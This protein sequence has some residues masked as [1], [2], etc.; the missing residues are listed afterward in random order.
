MSVPSFAARSRWL[1]ALAALALVFTQLMGTALPARAAGSASLTAAGTAYTE[2]FD[3]LVSTG[4]GTLAANTPL[5]WNFAESGTNANTIYTAGTGSNNAG[6]T[7]SFGATSASDRAFGGLLSGSVTPTIGASFINNTGSTIGALD[8]AYTGEQWRIG[9]TTTA[10]DDRLDF[11]YS[12]DATSLTTGTWVDVNSLD[13]TNPIKTAATTAALD[14]NAS[15]NR[16]AIS[17]SIT[18]QNIP[19]G[20]TFWIRWSDFN[21]TGSDDSLAIDDFSLT[22]QGDAATAPSITTGPQSQ[23]ITSGQTAT[24]SVVASGTTPLSY[25]WYQGSAGDTSAPVGANAASYTTPALTA[26]TSYWV[27]V[28]NSAGSADSGTATITVSPATDQPIATGGATSLATTEGS[29]ASAVVTASDPDSTITGATITSAAVTGIALNG[30]AST[31]N[32]SGSDASVS[33]DVGASVPAGSYPVDIQFANNTGQTASA[34]VAVTVNVPAGSCPTPSTAL[35]GIPALQG[36]ADTNTANGQNR[37][38]RGVVSVDVQGSPG[39]NGFYLQDPAGDGNLQTSDGVFVFVPSANSPWFGFDVAVGDALQ[40]SG[41][42]TEFQGMTEI[43]TVTSIV[44]CGTNATIAPATVHLPEATNGELERYEG[45]LVSIP[46]TLTVQQNFF[47]GRYGQVTLGVGGRLYQPTNRY[48]AGSAQA[49][50]AADSNARSMIVLD[51]ANSAQNPSALPYI[52]AGNTLRAGDTTSGLVGALDFGA[53]NS[54][55]TIHDYRLQPTQPVVFTRVNDRTAAPATVG[56]NLKVA[57]FNVLNYFN[58]DGQGGGFPTSRGANTLVEFNRQRDKIIAAITA[59]DPAVAG[60]MEM[61]NDG[62]GALSAVQDLVNGL[63]AATSPGKYALVAEPAPGSDQI[64]VAMIYQPA[65]V[66]PSGTAVNYQVGDP[67]YGAELFDRPPLAQTFQHVA[68]GQIFTVIVNHFKSKGSCPTSGPDTDQGDGQGCW[69]PKRTRQAQELLGFIGARQ[70]A[71]GDLDVLVIGDL[72]SYGMEDPIQ[73]LTAGGLVNTIQ[74]RIGDDAYSYV[75]DGMSGYLDHALATSSLDSQISG[76][77]EWHINADEPSVIDYN[78]EFKNNP[79]CTSTTCTSPDY[80]AATPFRAS[81]HDPVLVGLSLS[82]AP[83]PTNPSGVGSASPASVTAGSA[84]LLTVTVTPGANPASSGLSVS[85]DLTA[86]GGLATQAF[87]DNGTNG[88]ATAGDNIFSFSATVAAATTAGAKSLPFTVAD[89]QA[90]SG[91]GTIALT[92][93]APAASADVVISQVYGGGGNTGATFKNDFIELYNRG[94]TPADLTGWSVQYASAAN[95]FS[96]KTNLAGT[97]QPGQYYLIQEAAGTGGTTNLPTPDATGTIAMSAT[98]GKVALVNNQ[99]LL[100]CGAAANNCFPNSAIVDFV[101][102]GTTA[103]N[104]EGSGPAPAPSN[105][106]AALRNGNGATDT[107]NNSADFTVGTPTPR[108]SSFGQ[109]AS[110]SGV[111][112]ASPAS[113]TAGSATLLTVTVTPG[114]NPASSGLSVSADLTAIGGSATQAFVDNGT[115]GDATAGDNIFSFSATVAAATTAGAKSL[116][117]TVADAQ[118]RSGSGSIALTVTAAVACSAPDVA[119][120]S[121]Q[122]SGAATSASGTVTVQGVVVGDYEGASPAL[123][124]FYLQDS[125]DGDT[126]TS[127][128][129][130]VFEGDNANR[131]GVG[132]VV[133]V[134]GTPGENQGQTQISSTT[135]VEVCGSTA[136]LTPTDVALPV[137][138]AASGVDY[139]ER[140]EGMLVRFAQTLYVTEHFQ[141]GRFGQVVLSS[142]ERL[143]Q[144]TNV[145]APGAP[146]LALQAQN[147]LS[148]IILDDASQA[149]NPDPIVFARGGSP[150]SAANTLRGGDSVANLSGVMTYTWAGN[151]ASGNAYRIRPIGALGGGVPNFQPANPRPAAAPNVGGS[152]RVAGMNLL[153]FFN[154][155]DGLP[156]TVDNCTNGVGGAPTDCR[157]ADTQAEFDRQW[158]KTITAILALNPDVLGVNE[159]ENDGY[160]PTSAIQ[161]L[162]DKLNAATAPGTYAFIDV[163]TATGQTN[164][165]GTDAIKVAMLY[166]PAR[167]TPVGQTAALNSTAFV[168][169][170]DSAPR[171]RPSLAQAFEENATGARF[172]LDLNHLKSKGSACDA[173]DAGDGQG[174]CNTV[175][176]NAA[177]QLTAWLASNPT[178][179]GETDILLLGDY[180]SYAKEDPITAI[181]SAG[182]TNLIEQFLGADAYSYVFDGQWGYLDHALGSASIVGQVS[183]VGDYHINADEPSVL[184]YNTDFKTANLQSTLYAPDQFRVS[185]HDPVLVGLSL[186]VPNSPPVASDQSVTTAEDTP[187]SITL[188]ATDANAGD[189]L[190]YSVVAGP[191]HGSLSGTGAS[192]TY[193]PAANYNG[194][195]SFTFKANDG[196]ADSNVAT[197]SITITPVNDA[198][199]A[200]DQSVTTAEDTPASITLSANDVEGDSL[201]YSVVAG[202]AHGSLSG[203][204]AS[205]TYT[206]A[207]NYNGPDSF[208]FKANDGTADSNIATVTID[209]TAVNDAPAITIVPGGQCLADFQGLANLAL[210]DADGT[211]SL[212]LSASSSNT[213]LVPVGNVTFGGS[214]GARTVTIATAAGKTGSATV[215]ISVSDG[216]SSASLTISVKA[217][218]SGGDVLLGTGGADMLFGGN[219]VDQLLGGSGIDLLCGGGGVDQLFGGNG[220]D[221]LDG[222]SGND[223][224]FGDDGNDT[225]TGGS[226]NDQLFGGSGNDQLLGGDGNDLLTGG[227]GADHFDGGPNFDIAIDYQPSQGDTRVNIP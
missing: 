118:A 153:N 63:N 172:I 12:T 149:Q 190:S 207:A 57:S 23:A 113:V 187:A 154:T 141:L 146:A 81:D 97:L 144:P 66:S 73:A 45:M 192:L 191:A 152:L 37:T 223:Q 17:G 109:P 58:G 166:K 201:T 82:G 25:Q 131:V 193:T 75:F 104:Y 180:N 218:G 31:P 115:N 26:S 204:G 35:V 108:N 100:T 151:A 3:T 221:A 119:I 114:A 14:G 136:S 93:T 210:A 39:Q 222:G 89:A 28:S 150:L 214:A 29:A 216:T 34:S 46:E 86:I 94:T 164:A 217:G 147:D 95:A 163:D 16:T 212:T 105:T 148:K 133:Q 6:D 121:V 170:G 40:V 183:G 43:D 203:S 143:R 177:N 122:G 194:P 49:I 52:G 77:T 199:V 106:T 129:I 179:T 55:T 135:G 38:V 65:L 61:E 24:L 51:D 13:F 36:T 19:N 59:I 99:A 162:T 27:R 112:S 128:G 4:T 169:G 124:G 145:A 126:T 47:L 11:Q 110:P 79:N 134:T 103:N 76:V 140:F 91:S 83:T 48:D 1:R 9:N 5:G 78:V 90:R 219:G 226:G 60:L 127:D 130:F 42:A 225:L 173:P 10:R 160:G 69:N 107:N 41:R 72:N 182:Y 15:A 8:I 220:D 167:V 181:K 195:D 22:P 70:A 30:F 206:P 116:P 175:R 142:G 32:G 71:S 188:V 158:P 20:A 7:Y 92:V 80:Y 67:T 184:D 205:L 53:I 200:S 196:T 101:G 111:G 64:K 120:G 137:P 168:N 138:A 209:V 178:G 44:K 224:L 174:N 62:S 171:S 156:D 56:G 54:D 98:A 123:R 96:S 176:T 227:S 125:G 139:L 21:A 88:D 161:F 84:T 189:T 165:L 87:V 155:F 50:T 85:A 33:L 215:T 74:Q 159:I 102:F 132:Q 213:T 157:G 185:D 18:G 117:F 202:P 208:T 186:T 2:N 198:P 197:V 68:T 211:G